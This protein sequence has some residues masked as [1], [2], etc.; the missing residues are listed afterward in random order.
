MLLDDIADLLTTGAIST[1][2][3]KGFMPE[4][5]DDAFAVIETGG[6]P[7]VHA[8]SSGPGNASLEHPTFQLIR[9]S[10][11]YVTARNGM[12]SAFDLLDGLQQRTINGT[13]YAYVEATQSPFNLGRDESERTRIVVNFSA[14]KELTSV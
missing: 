5:P 13:R 1:D 7:A 3:Y 12:Q 11:S 2:I 10:A 14:Y 6:F 9:R 4:Q 8:M